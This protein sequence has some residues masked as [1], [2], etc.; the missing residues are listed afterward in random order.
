[1]G[2]LK[3]VVVGSMSHAGC[4]KFA[5]LAHFAQIQ[6]FLLYSVVRTYLQFTPLQRFHQVIDGLRLHHD[7]DGWK[8]WEQDGLTELLGTIDWYMALSKRIDRNL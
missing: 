2:T 8:R 3:T 4:M 5:T 7:N 1:M 6:G